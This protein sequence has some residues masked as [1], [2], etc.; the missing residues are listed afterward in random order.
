MEN[1]KLCP[2]CQFSNSLSNTVCE[3]CSTPLLTLLPARI[4]VPVPESLVQAIP[5]AP[6]PQTRTEN[7]VKDAIAFYMVGQ[8]KPILVKD[9]IKKIIFGRSSPGES[10]PTVDLTP[11]DAHL[12][13]VSR[14]HAIIYR[15]DNGCFL[16][17]LGSTNGTYLNEKRL[18]A[19]KLYALENGDLV[20]LGQLGFRAYFETASTVH[21]IALIDEVNP[22]QQI[23]PS[24]LEQRISPYIIALANAQQL[25][26]AMQDRPLSV[27][28]IRKIETEKD[29]RIYVTLAGAR[30]ILR[31][32]DTQLSEW[33]TA[34]MIMIERLRELNDRVKSDIRAA[35]EIKPISDPLRVDLRNQLAQFA[36]VCVEAIAANLNDTAKQTYAEKLCAPLQALL[37]S[38]LQPVVLDEAHKAALVEQEAR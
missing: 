22:G 23:T 29:G 12:F 37:F 5:P 10:M 35:Q 21:T 1:I 20:R 30:D 18:V 13:G 16:Q 15:S 14:Q 25:L 38:P 11:Y 3:R 28:A 7:E 17:D 2:T 19:Q 9:D 32:V 33:R 31:L 6:T 34:R 4:T 24:Y 8:A 27:I 36:R 26:D